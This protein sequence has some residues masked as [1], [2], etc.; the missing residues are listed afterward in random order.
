LGE[1]ERSEGE[2]VFVSNLTE[3]KKQLALTL[4]SPDGR[5]FLVLVAETLIKLQIKKPL[6]FSGFFYVSSTTQFI[7]LYVTPAKAGVHLPV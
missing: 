3:I 4:P 7:T 6:V 5:G 1:V 2:G